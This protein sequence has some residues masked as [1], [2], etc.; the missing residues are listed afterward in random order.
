MYTTLILE[1]KKYNISESQIRKVY[2]EELH[3]LVLEKYIPILEG[4]QQSYEEN[5]ITEAEYNRLTEWSFKE[6]K[7]KISDFFNPE[8]RAYRKQ[9]KE[10]L[11]AVGK[12]KADF[13][14]MND[15]AINK[16]MQDYSSS[17][18]SGIS[19]EKIHQDFIKVLRKDQNLTKQ[20]AL[21]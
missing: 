4:I 11:K 10:Q 2:R 12:I 3:N 6:I 13:P 5:L 17:L 15:K 7:A 14:Y 8:K 20:D 21:S 19:A 18:A 1:G 9:K 16:I